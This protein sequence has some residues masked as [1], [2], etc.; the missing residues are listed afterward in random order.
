M[1]ARLKFLLMAETDG[2]LP[3]FIGHLFRAAFLDLIKLQNPDL[4]KKLHDTS[5][6]R[7]YCIGALSSKDQL[8]RKRAGEIEIKKDTTFTMTMNFFN[9]ELVKSLLNTFFDD[10]PTQILLK[11]ISFVIV[12]V[13]ISRIKYQE[14][15]ETAERVTRFG[16]SFIT[17]SQFSVIGRKFPLTF[18]EPR[19]I[20]SNLANQWNKYSPEVK[21]DLDLF[22]SF[23][24]NN[25]Y[26]RD[27]DL[28]TREVDLGKKI[29]FVGCIGR[30][31]YVAR[32]PNDPHALWLDILGRFGEYSNV[33]IKR[34]A[35]LGVINYFRIKYLQK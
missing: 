27:Y 14:L 26:A 3:P 20:F 28:I 29:P 12:N 16:I 30:C 32:D 13:M 6:I 5:N 11:N 23:V 33:G 35:G 31:S 10:K 21:I 9:Q 18:P 24:S 1:I 19:L 22:H 4:A 34:T 25:V 15:F 17:P 8:R 7:P 2:V